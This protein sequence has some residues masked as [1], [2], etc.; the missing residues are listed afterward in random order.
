MPFKRLMITVSSLLF[1]L[2]LLIPG[3]ASAE[4]VRLQ[5]VTS[6]TVLA[7]I[8]RAIG[9]DSVEVTSIVG[10]NS[11]AHVYRAR[12]ADAKKITSADILIINGLGF[13]GWLE[14]L[15]QSSGFAGDL[16]VMTDA[17]EPLERVESTKESSVKAQLFGH[18]HDGDD[19]HAWHSLTNGMHYAR[20]IAASLIQADPQREE[21]YRSALD[22]FIQR[23]ERV[24]DELHRLVEQLPADGRR[25]IT[26]H[27]AFQYLGLEY[28]F[29]F[30]APQGVSTESEPSARDVALLIRQ[31]RTEN[32]AAVFIENVSD[33]RLMRQIASETGAAIGGVLYSGALSE[34]TG[35]APTYLKM[36]EHNVTT[37]V[38]ALAGD[39]GTTVSRQ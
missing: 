28:G 17:I 9:G 30:V 24:N 3:I 26:S 13:E 34:E 31:I 25:V 37:L 32:I 10:A 5:V 2:G 36:M 16:V 18:N 22:R 23:A 20:L 29:E 7:D 11:D 39:A 33:D 14:R 4:P 15:V 8:T 19:P 21:R 27:D 1:S 38:Q 12:P 6:F 35:P